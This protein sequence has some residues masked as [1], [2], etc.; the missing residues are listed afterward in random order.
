M[1]IS[2]SV[3]LLLAATA[4]LVVARPPLVYSQ[5]SA[6][7][8]IGA[9]RDIPGEV[10]PGVVVRL[11]EVTTRTMLQEVK[12][13]ISG[14]FVF[15]SVP[16]GAYD[17]R[18][19]YESD[20][21]ATRR[22][23]VRS[24][25]PVIVS[26]DSL[27]E[28]R[29]PEVLVT[30]NRFGD[31]QSGL[32]SST[33]YTAASVDNLPAS[34]STKQIETLLLDTPGVVPDE[35][36][37][38]HVRGED[39]QLQYVIDGIPVTGNLT[40]VYSSMFNAQLIKSVDVLTGS[41]NAEYGVA[42]AGV[43]AITTKSGF[44]KPFFVDATA[45]TGSFNTREG[46]LQVG[47]NVGGRAAA[48]VGLNGSASSRYLDPITS[49]DPN[50]DDGAAYNYFG[51]FHVL[52]NDRTDLSLLTTYNA[53]KYSVPNS[54]SGTPGQDQVQNLDDYLIGLR[55]NT[56]VNENSML[57]VLAYRRQSTAKVTSGG[58]M[59]LQT[60]A[61]F[62][63]AIAENEKFF[64]GGDRR[65]TMTGGQVEFSSKPEWFSLFNTF[66]AGITAE[67]FP[68]HEQFSFAVTNPA[69]SDTAVAG[70]DLRYRPYDITQGGRPFSV[71]QSKTGT[72]FSGFVQNE[73]VFD[74][75]IVS[76]GIRFDAFNF[77]QDEFAVSPRIGASYRVN[78]D[79]SLRASYNRVVMQAPLENILVS[80]SDEARKLTGAD[81]GTIP[82]SV[83]SEKEHVLELGAGYRLND[84]VDFDLVGYG[85]LI[86]DFLVKVELGNSGVIFPVNLKKGFV[87]GGELRGRLY[88][89][90]G[91]S[92][93]L[94]MST[95]ASYGLKPDDGSS[96]IAAGLI[97]GEE[98]QNYN[99]P[100]AGEN[101]FPT[102]HNQLL[103]AVLNLQY[104]HPTGA[105]AGLN[106]RFDS[107]LPFDLVGK[108]GTGLSPD[109]SRVELR[110]RGYSDSVI[111]LLTLQSDQP[112]SPDKSVAPHAVFDLTFGYDAAPLLMV[113]VRFT[114]TV[115]NVLDSPF[116]Y[117]FESSFGGTHFGYPR[118]VTARLDVQL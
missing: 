95:C 69:L 110:R 71:D 64:I 43:L 3:R 104:K 83:R 88:D 4:I 90:H 105:F 31:R 6:G 14:R 109:E 40:R 30:A 23:V 55:L 18:V 33:T 52:L 99:H 117:K 5:Q 115:M 101:M 72:R 57:S 85:K 100:F 108:D 11:L 12:P 36:G 74:Q 28:F 37:R 15:R 112:G 48:Y 107:G 10:E 7:I 27:Q 96:P 78:P 89:W 35:D 19:C 97:L 56:V 8:I 73:M 63:K 45:G 24:S 38:M 59:N 46:G 29:E 13:E 114:A 22:I 67:V 84:H 70:G 2:I 60:P 41:L 54:I 53:T 102:E 79:L 94:S 65:Y 1:K 17:L 32:S 111:D 81:Q 68:V 116:L 118:M 49:G 26:I 47:G 98:G 39:A 103:T 92:G 42:T 50:H 82:S 20:V 87:A 93:F 16:F 51:K 76:A 80:S 21:L 62:A 77:L 75:W 86:D 25:I 106:G 44:D 91:F 66:K 9:M 58:L 113:P 34:S 61:D